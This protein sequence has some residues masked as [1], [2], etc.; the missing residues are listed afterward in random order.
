M[1]KILIIILCIVP[2]FLITGCSSKLNEINYKKFENLVNEKKNFIIYVGSADCHNC[3]EFSPKFERIIKEYK[4]SNVYYV[5]LSKFNDEEKNSFNKIINVSGTP[6]VA[7][8]KNGEEESSFNRINGNVS[9]E[10]IKSRLKSNN[11]I[12]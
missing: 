5:D 12:K 9:E 10:K 2:L 7:F 3:T 11:Y 8:I 1:K 6:T 4:I